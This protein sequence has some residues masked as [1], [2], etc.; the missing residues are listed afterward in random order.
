M[1][2]Q[3]PLLVN[4]LTVTENVLLGQTSKEWLTNTPEDTARIKEL[5][6]RYGFQIDP[7]KEVWRLS[8]G[9]HQRVEIL[10]ALYRGVRVLILDEPTSVLTPQESELLF[11]LLRSMASQGISLVY[12]SHKLEEVIA[13]ADRATVMRSGSVVGTVD[14]PSTTI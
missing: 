2:H 8:A 11:T 3:R 4:R 14:I 1:V 5:C 12:I 9:E 6:A 10:K 13:L 7:Q